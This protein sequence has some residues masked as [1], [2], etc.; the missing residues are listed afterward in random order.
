MLHQHTSL[1]CAYQ[2]LNQPVV[3]TPIQLCV[4][5]LQFHTSEQQ[6]TAKDV[7][8]FSVQHWNS[9]PLKDFVAA[10]L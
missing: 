3:V 7:L 2:S 5:T 4:V 9:F 8:L 6:D 10:K 1:N